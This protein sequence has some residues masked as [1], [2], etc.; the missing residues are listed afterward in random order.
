MLRN[1]MG[2]VSNFKKTSVTIV[3]GS[4]LGTIQVLR[5]SDEGVNFS[6]KNHYEGVR[7]NVISVARGGWVLNFQEKALR[8]TCMAHDVLHEFAASYVRSQRNQ[9]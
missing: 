1:A 7:F 5:N 9:F 4:T 2:V 3:Y 6:G 8:T